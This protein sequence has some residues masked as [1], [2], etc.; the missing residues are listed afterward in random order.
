MRKIAHEYEEII[1]NTTG[2]REGKGRDGQG[3][4][5][6]GGR[7]R[8][9]RERESRVEKAIIDRQRKDSLREK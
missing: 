8:W 7:G 1:K 3:E 2:V 4:G 6:G 5:V 9:E